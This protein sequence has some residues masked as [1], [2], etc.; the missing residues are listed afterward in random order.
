MTPTML[1]VQMTTVELVYENESDLPFRVSLRSSDDISWRVF[2][3]SREEA[4]TL[5]DGLTTALRRAKVPYR[6][7]ITT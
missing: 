5:R 7:E 3:L 2:R 6:T 1:R 4:A